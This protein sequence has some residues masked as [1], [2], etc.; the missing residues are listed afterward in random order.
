MKSWIFE[1]E[2]SDGTAWVDVCVPHVSQ[3]VH[4][5]FSDILVGVVEV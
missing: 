4:S 2:P 1:C 5:I 3:A